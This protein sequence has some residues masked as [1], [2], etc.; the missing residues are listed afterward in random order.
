MSTKLAL[1]LM[2]TSLAVGQGNRIKVFIS[3]TSRPE[4]ALVTQ[5]GEDLKQAFEKIRPRFI[6]SRSRCSFR[7]YR[8]RGRII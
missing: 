1:L 2:L 6:S 8:G 7:N 4:S 5:L 3:V